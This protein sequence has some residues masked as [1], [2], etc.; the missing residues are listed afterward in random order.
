MPKLYNTIGYPSNRCQEIAQISNIIYKAMEKDGT[1]RVYLTG[2]KGDKF[3]STAREVFPESGEELVGRS[4]ISVIKRC[5]YRCVYLS[6]PEGVEFL[7]Y[8]EKP[9]G[10]SFFTKKS[11]DVPQYQDLADQISRIDDRKGLTITL[12]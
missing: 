5:E 2:T 4:A 7:I 8:P 9:E 1:T 12:R 11:I 10:E 6:G 3:L